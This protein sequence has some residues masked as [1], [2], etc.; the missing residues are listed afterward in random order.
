MIP[1]HDTTWE[2]L[3]VQETQI[4]L[5]TS[6]GI[7]IGSSRVGAGRLAIV[8]LLCGIFMGEL[9]LKTWPAFLRPPDPN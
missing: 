8:R 4:R 2:T 5:S 3:L 7:V 6:S 1:L 9:R